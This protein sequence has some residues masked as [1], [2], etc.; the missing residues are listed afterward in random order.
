M[1]FHIG[2]LDMQVILTSQIE[3]V[4]LFPFVIQFEMV[5]NVINVQKTTTTQ[6]IGRVKRGEGLRMGCFCLNTFH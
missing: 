6:H 5:F 4:G 2:F 3:F 1:S